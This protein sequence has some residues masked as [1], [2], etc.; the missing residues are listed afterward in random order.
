[1]GLHGHVTFD[2]QLGF[3]GT[4]V[5]TDRGHSQHMASPFV[6]N[7]ALT[8]FEASVAHALSGRVSGP[9]DRTR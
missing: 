5:A 8:R 3:E 6:S 1:M 7:R 9:T 2:L 4:L